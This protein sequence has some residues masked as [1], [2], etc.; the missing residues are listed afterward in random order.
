MTS[1][2]PY[3]AEWLKSRGWVEKFWVAKIKTQ[4]WTHPDHDVLEPTKE[5]IRIE[6]QRENKS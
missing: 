3:T 2:K 4:Y 5:A 6:K 1:P